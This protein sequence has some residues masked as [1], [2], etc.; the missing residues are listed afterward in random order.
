MTTIDSG[1]PLQMRDTTQTSVARSDAA[2]TEL[3]QQDFLQLLTAQLQN[4]D[5]LNPMEN[6]QF[7]G[8][9][10]QFSTV[11]GIDRMN[12]TL[13]SLQGGL[14]EFRI[15]SASNLLGRQALVE[16]DVARA[17][18]AGDIRGVA[19]L[20]APAAGLVIEFADA[21]TGVLLHS[22]SYGAQA[23]GSIDFAWRDLPS[24]LVDDGRVVRVRAIADTTGGPQDVPT[25]VYARVTGVELGGSDGVPTL[26][27]EDHG[28]RPA[29]DIAALRADR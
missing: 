19:T 10:A 14:S 27:I 20:D 28:R 7:L 26:N 29:T 24:A 23:A 21:K 15:A 17:D 12:G 11:S 4:Q 3:G 6:T 2:D 8:Q 25:S 1:L 16:G 22:E 18:T 9:M 5:P 13:A